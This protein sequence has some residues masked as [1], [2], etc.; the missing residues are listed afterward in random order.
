MTSSGWLIGLG[1]LVA[2]VAIGYIIA[3]YSAPTERQIKEMADRAER[4]EDEYHQY[5]A[6]VSDHFRNTAEAVAQM[7]KS[8]RD[9]YRQ[10]ATGAERLCDDP[11]KQ[12]LLAFEETTQQRLD[13]KESPRREEKQAGSGTAED[14]PENGVEPPRDYPVT[15]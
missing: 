15:S 8:Y 10:L 5:R 6:E 3:R 7:T 2:G 11:V 12:E 1:L 4:V 9:V 14:L 13:V